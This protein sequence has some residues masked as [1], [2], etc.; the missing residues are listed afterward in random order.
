MRRRWDVAATGWEAER[1]TVA[2]INAPVTA[3]LVRALDPRPDHTVLDLAGGTGDLAEALAGRVAGIVETD[4]SPVMVEAARKRGIANAEHRVMDMQEIDLPDASVDG[5]VSRFGYMLVP[6]PALAFRET[7]RVLRPGGTLALAT[8][9]PAKRN[10]WATAYGPVLIDRGLQEP[11]APGE[12]GQ[13]ALSEPERIEELVRGAGFAEIEVE[14]VPVEYRFAAWEDYRRV[15][16]SLAASLRA[17]L[18]GLE[19]D[20]RA[21]VD[22]AAR[23]RIEHFRGDDGYVIPGVALVARSV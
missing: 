20:V 23:A 8:W 9:A 22:D 6:D 2:A 16:N 19:D 7:R 10:P 12:P 21:E 18:E 3:A 17:V 4:L 13:F 1:E 5:V 11:P 15:I 14:E